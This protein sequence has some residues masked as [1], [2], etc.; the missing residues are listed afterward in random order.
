MATEQIVTPKDIEDRWEDILTWM[1]MDD[2]F[3]HEILMILTKVPTTSVRTMGVLVDNSRLFLLYNPRFVGQLT[4]AEMRYVLTHEVFHIVLHH[5]T[6]RAPTDPHSHRLY[7]IA[8][9]LAINSLIVCN[10]L[11][12]APTGENAGVMPA[13]YGF[14]EKLSMEQYIALLRDQPPPPP[15]K[16]KERSEDEEGGGGGAEQE[17]DGGG[18]DDQD[19]EGKKDKGKPGKDKGKGGK[20]S[21]KDKEDDKEDTNPPGFDDHSGWDESEIIKEIIRNKVD[22][23][24]KDEKVWGSMPGDLQNTILAAQRSRVLWHKILRHYLGNLPTSRSQSTYTKPNRR[25]GWPYCGE[26]RLYIDRKLVGIDTSGSISDEDLAQFLTEINKLSEIQPVDIQLFDH[27]LQGKVRP[28]ARKHARYK[29]DGRGGT[30]FQSIMD[31]AEKKR[32]QSLILLTDGA[33][34][35]PTQP[36]HVRDI[37][38]VLTEGGKKPVPWGRDIQIVPKNAQKTVKK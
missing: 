9:D 12:K 25:F 38:W 5:C 33:A 36:K 10:T 20:G 29:F 22:Q 30:E 6:L 3:V 13:T 21:S 17:S 7:N 14:E 32:Y 15:S 23:L 1:I 4:D 37:L 34:A 8:A 28:F 26:K 27:G 35:P 2:P 19:E 24:S 16:R 11:R 31:L 18:S